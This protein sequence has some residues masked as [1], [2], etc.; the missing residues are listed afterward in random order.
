MIFQEFVFSVDKRPSAGQRM[1]RLS[2]TLVHSSPAPASVALVSREG[3]PGP[4]IFI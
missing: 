1:D 4:A 2:G 3:F